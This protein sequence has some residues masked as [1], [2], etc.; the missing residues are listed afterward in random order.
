MRDELVVLS[1]EGPMSRRLI[2]RILRHS[3]PRGSQ[4]AC[5]RSRRS[6]RDEGATLARKT[7]API[8]KRRRAWKRREEAGS[9]P[10]T[11][12]WHAEQPRK[13]GP[14]SIVESGW[15]GSNWTGVKRD[16]P[17]VTALPHDAPSHSVPGYN[18]P[19]RVSIP[20]VRPKAVRRRMEPR[21][22]IRFLAV[23]VVC[24]SER[25]LLGTCTNNI[26]VQDAP[27]NRSMR[28]LS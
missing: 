5:S 20:S 17:R 9:F 22:A 6:R 1:L 26:Y 25:R 4:L 11:A 16:W 14:W 18:A 12:R 3:W 24:R 10:T 21:S 2:R 8:M 15:E 28:L 23:P 13:R 27:V 19:Q 7:T